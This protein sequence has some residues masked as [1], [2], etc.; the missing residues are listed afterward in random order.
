[1]FLN[2][3]E[4]LLLCLGGK[5]IGERREAFDVVVVVCLSVCMY[6]NGEFSNC[7]KNLGFILLCWDV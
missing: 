3:R 6:S 7:S 5:S 4:V 1:M 2:F